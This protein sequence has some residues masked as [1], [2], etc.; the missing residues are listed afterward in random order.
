MFQALI[1]WENLLS[2]APEPVLSSRHGDGEMQKALSETQRGCWA[3]SQNNAKQMLSFPFSY[4]LDPADINS[5]L[6]IHAGLVSYSMYC[7]KFLNKLFSLNIG[8]ALFW[9]EA[10][11]ILIE[12]WIVLSASRLPIF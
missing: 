8:L 4:P 11:H 9:L 7:T 3:S 1:L 5:F 10:L 2:T 6:S 12:F